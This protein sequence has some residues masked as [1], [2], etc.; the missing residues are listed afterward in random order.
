VTPLAAAI[1]SD[2]S[3]LV[4]STLTLNAGAA[5]SFVHANLS[6]IAANQLGVSDLT[7]LLIRP[8]G[9]VGLRADRDHLRTL[10]AYQSMLTRSEAVGT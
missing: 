7:L 9:H 4:D 5:E 8:D 10:Q 1:E 3:T 6:A 2:G